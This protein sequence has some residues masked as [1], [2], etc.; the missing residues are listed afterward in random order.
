[1][2]ICDILE[3]IDLFDRWEDVVS[4]PAQ[5]P[6]IYM[7]ALFPHFTILSCVELL[8]CILDD[9]KAKMNKIQPWPLLWSYSWSLTSGL[10]APPEVSA[11][12]GVM[13]VFT[14]FLTSLLKDFKIQNLFFFL[15]LYIQAAAG[16]ESR[17]KPCSCVGRWKC[18]MC[19]MTSAQQLLF[20]AHINII[21][22]SLLI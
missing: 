3:K 7:I 20:L 21:S 18:Q 12:S 1:M 17:G 8:R 15:P 19:T 10:A 11:V 14:G 4:S 22:L 2:L 9:F 6:G 5:H 16:T 13:T